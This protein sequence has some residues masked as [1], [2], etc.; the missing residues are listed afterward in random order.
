MAA[1]A[2]VLIDGDC[3]LCRVL[4]GWLARRDHAGRLRFATL[5]SPAG[6]RELLSHGLPTD[7]HDSLVFIPGDGT[8]ARLRSAGALAALT[9]LG[10]IW[11]GL[12]RIGSWV[13]ARWRDG[14][15]RI[16]ARLRHRVLGPPRPGPW[17]TGPLATR[18]PADG[19]PTNPA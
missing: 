9:E 6:R 8:P 4:A 1:P 3:G 10:G 11:S 15:Y 18:F 7:D 14:L 2:L 17:P 16:V 12:A 19:R 13:P 5:A